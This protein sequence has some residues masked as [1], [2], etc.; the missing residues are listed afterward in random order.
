MRTH[1]PVIGHRFDV[2]AKCFYVLVLPPFCEYAQAPRRLER[3]SWTLRDDVCARAPSR[4]REPGRQ[5]FRCRGPRSRSRGRAGPRGVRRPRRGGRAF[6]SSGTD[7]ASVFRL[8]SSSAGKSGW[9]PQLC[10]RLQLG[11]L[12]GLECVLASVSP[13]EGAGTP[14]MLIPALSGL[15]LLLLFPF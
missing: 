11:T 1:R 15:V 14:C 13:V 6:S 9:E 4:K 10:D 5:M 7:T 2:R 12:S 8:R 3:S